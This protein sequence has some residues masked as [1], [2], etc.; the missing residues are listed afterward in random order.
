MILAAWYG[1]AAL[2]DLLLDHD[3]EA[4]LKDAVSGSAPLAA[5]PNPCD[6]PAATALKS[7]REAALAGRR[8]CGHI[9]KGGGGVQMLL[10]YF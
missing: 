7:S 4:A 1:D 10:F 8:G 6:T 2:M 3:A 9:V 5:A